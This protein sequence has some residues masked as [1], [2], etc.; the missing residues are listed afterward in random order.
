M[1]EMIIKLF[2]IAYYVLKEEEPF[3]T[4]PKL[5]NLLNLNGL[6]LGNTYKND[7]ACYTFIERIAK[8]IS[9]S[10]GG[11]RKAAPTFL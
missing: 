7:H 6:N 10:G 5:L 8:T 3:I 1:K 2:N 11:K 9:D 4:F